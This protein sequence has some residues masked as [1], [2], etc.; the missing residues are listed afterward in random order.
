MAVPI[1]LPDLGPGMAGGIVAEWYRPDGTAVDVGEVVCRVECEFIALEVEAEGPGV[2]RHRKPAGSIERPG[3]VLGLIL[4]PGESMP[5]EPPPQ[6]A[7]GPAPSPV[8]APPADLARPEEGALE[9][10]AVSTA[11]E[12]VD[13]AAA[14]EPPAVPP[15][16][17]VVQFPRRFTPQPGDQWASAPGDAVEFESALFGSGPADRA[18]VL[19]EP[20]ASI[21]GLPL[22]EPE[23]LATVPF[24]APFPV[25]ATTVPPSIEERFARISAEAEASAQVLAMTVAVDMTEANRLVAVC[26]RE[27][28]EQPSPDASDVVFRAL[29]LALE[30]TGHAGGTGAM[31]ISE[32]ESDISLAIQVPADRTFRAAVEAR[33]E[34]GDSAFESADWLLVS[35][36]ALGVRTA[37]PRLNGG[38]AMAFA[39]GDVDT[40][41]R[42]TLT[43]AYDS[44]RWSEG[45]A[46]RFLA[47]TRALLESPYA[48][49]V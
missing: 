23:D 18:D 13:P 8:E 27:W 21:P 41:G 2:L 20:G 25:A 5:A 35:L 31:V 14:S 46:A 1:A 4:A 33:A 43:M 19:P 47:R 44:S 49:L 48:M 29:A 22:W 3:S 37:T 45:S 16:A 36:A 40:T 10:A 6:P 9:E 7:A 24:A 28:R 11:E 38:R 30:H 34:G 32:A 12:G 39:V 42:A 15:E 26:R 17:V